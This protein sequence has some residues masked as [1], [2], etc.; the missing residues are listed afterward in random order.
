MIIRR[1]RSFLPRLPKNTDGSEKSGTYTEKTGPILPNPHKKRPS[2]YEKVR[3]NVSQCCTKNTYFKRVAA[4][5][6]NSV[7]K[8]DACFTVNTGDGAFHAGA[9]NGII[10]MQERRL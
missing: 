7:E 3:N 6:G 5:C 9:K 4:G 2:S 1:L 8:I 10:G